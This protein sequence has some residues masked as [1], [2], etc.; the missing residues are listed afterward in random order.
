MSLLR[1]LTAGKSLVGLRDGEHRYRVPRQR[2]L[3]KFDARANPFMAASKPGAPELPQEKPVTA[4]EATA[5][6][7]ERTAPEPVQ[8]AA[9]AVLPAAA[10]KFETP[11]PANAPAPCRPGFLSR[12]LRRGTPSHRKGQA[13]GPEALVQ[14]ELSLEAVKVVRNDLNDSDLE[15]APVQA[16]KAEPRAPEGQTTPASTDAV[17]SRGGAWGRVSSRLFGAGKS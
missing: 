16:R 6:R 7:E 10:P 5:P 3:P 12:V 13:L 8:L 9:P 1:L 11:S 15:L 14:G 2:V 17:A 4:A